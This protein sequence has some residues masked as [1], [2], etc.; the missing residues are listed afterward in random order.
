MRKIVEIRCLSLKPGTRA[1]FH[2]IYVERALAPLRRWKFD[3]VAFG[4]SL[5][6]EDTYHVIRAFDSLEQR[7]A[8]EDAYYDSAEWREGPR[9]A[10]L[11]LIDRYADVVIEMDP[12]AVDSL[13]KTG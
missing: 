11:A 8:M 1:E 6:D 13:R 7:Q 3:V 10:I 2:R 4:P 5:H 12:A 9:E